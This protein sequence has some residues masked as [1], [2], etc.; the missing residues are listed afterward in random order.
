MQN[1]EH[2]DSWT[3]KSW[4]D[5]FISNPRLAKDLTSIYADDVLQSVSDS[6]FNNLEEAIASLKAEVG[7]T[8]AEVKDIM[9][10]VVAKTDPQS[11]VAEQN[12]RKAGRKA[13]SQLLVLATTT[14][15]KCNNAPCDCSHVLATP[16]AKA[17]N[18]IGLVE[19]AEMYD[20]ASAD[21]C[22]TCGA[23][24]TDMQSKS[25]GLCGS[26]FSDS[27]KEQKASLVK[28]LVAEGS[29]VAEAMEKAAKMNPGFEAFLKN[30]KEEGEGGQASDK[31][32]VGKD[33]AAE[34]AASLKAKAERWAEFLTTKG[35]FQGADAKV[36][37]GDGV[38]TE[39]G[40]SNDP[41]ALGYNSS[42]GVHYDK[43]ALEVA[44][45]PV[46]NEEQKAFEKAALETG[47]GT[48]GLL[49]D[50]KEEKVKELWQRA[51]YMAKVKSLRAELKKSPK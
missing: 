33:K 51:K 5:D 35:Y 4:L 3:K 9:K 27:M 21:T 44:G 41:N 18:R 30:K 28:T 2:M 14:C 19:L 37:T 49:G 45:G 23:E 50:G 1:N 29:S 39:H 13:L 47:G 46:R 7:L 42:E 24:L 12:I 48:D 15:D 34:K 25:K 43:N 6:S 38:S 32:T 40:N 8:T 26:C 10:I 22:K 31:E 17:I 20:K 36:N 16:I 11:F